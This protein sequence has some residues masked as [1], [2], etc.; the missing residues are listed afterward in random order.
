[1]TDFNIKN[2]QSMKIKFMGAT[3]TKGSRIKITDERFEESVTL[4]YDYKYNNGIE[5]AIEYLT[6][7]G[8]NLI[9]RTED[10]ILTDTFKPLR[11][12]V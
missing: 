10:R 11:E 6:N 8:F 12:V 3:N 2:M 7:K 5:Q 4:C 1:M 9:G